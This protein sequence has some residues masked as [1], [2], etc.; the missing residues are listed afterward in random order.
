VK[1]AFIKAQGV[2]HAVDRMCRV[3]DVSRSGYYSWL[4]RPES[5]RKRENRS[6]L[7]LIEQIHVRS[8][9]TYGYPRVHAE[10]RAQQINCGR[11][12]V[13]RLMRRAGLKTCMQRLWERSSRGRTFEHIGANKLDR[14][15]HADAMNNR[16]VSDYTF[17]PTAEGWL[18]LAV[19][20]DLFSRSIVGWS[21]SDKRNAQL[22]LDA[23]RMALNRR[24]KVAGLMLHSDQGMEYRTAEYHK[25][26]K[27]NGIECSMS[28]KGNC[29]DNAAM[30]SFFHTLKTEHV[31]QRRY[32]TR[33]EARQSLFEYIE[34]FY[35]RQRRHS[36]LNYMTPMEFEKYNAIPNRMSVLSG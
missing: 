4:M 17:V 20:M 11:N 25:T 15:F 33:D 10:L 21:M 23:L 8:R 14:Q 28:R 18:Y 12:R 26:M 16:W 34:V 7:S 27:A 36:Y 31:H 2:E 32:K 35:N 19:L 6:L 1:Y 30:E 5:F 9:Q 24:G 22:T 13:A 3:L 29:L